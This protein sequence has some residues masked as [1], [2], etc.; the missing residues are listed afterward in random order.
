MF[1]GLNT[2]PVFGSI[3]MGGFSLMV[4]SFIFSVSLDFN[5]MISFDFSILLVSQ[6]SHS[7]NLPSCNSSNAL[8]CDISIPHVNSTWSA[9]YDIGRNFSFCKVVLES[10][11]LLRAQET[12]NV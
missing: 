11:S 6:S 9:F 12:P 4:V 1:N 8:A 5:E 3:P 10:Y 2:V 7:D